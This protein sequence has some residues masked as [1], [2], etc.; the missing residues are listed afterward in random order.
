[1]MRYP[2]MMYTD[3]SL[4]DQLWKE[5]KS[6]FDVAGISSCLSEEI[7]IQGVM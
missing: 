1:M 2:P 5:T 6:E 7:K 4:I 3:P